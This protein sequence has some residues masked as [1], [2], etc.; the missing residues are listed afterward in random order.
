MYLFLIIDMY[1]IFDDRVDDW[2]HLSLCV[3]N[4]HIKSIAVS[5]INGRVSLEVLVVHM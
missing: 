4:A 1:M 2:I 3:K 5:S